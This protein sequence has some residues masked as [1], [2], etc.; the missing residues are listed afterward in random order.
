MDLCFWQR[1]PALAQN[2]PVFLYGLGYG[3]D[4]LLRDL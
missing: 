4:K 1:L 2:K 3:V